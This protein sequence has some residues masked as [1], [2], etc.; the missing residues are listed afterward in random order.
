MLEAMMPV[1]NISLMNPYLTEQA[2]IERRR[3]LYEALQAQSM[4]PIEQQ[5]TPPGGFAVPIR[6]TQ[7]LA[8]IA[9]A[10]AAAYGQSGAREQSKALGER[11]TKERA[12]V[13][14]QALKAG[15]AIPAQPENTDI[16][17]SNQG[18]D[19]FDLNPAKA[20]VPADRT[21]VYEALA[22]NQSFPDLQ[23]IGIT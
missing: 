12:D 14:S 1:Q 21:R 19:T 4:Q 11:Y 6:P 9:Q 13:V 16:M 3:K 10:L 8:K 2:D 17:Q 5:P 22:A 7:G 15:E 18:L 23:N 20:A